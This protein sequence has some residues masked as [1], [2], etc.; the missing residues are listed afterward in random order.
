MRRRRRSAERVD[1]GPKM[2]VMNDDSAVAA[3]EAG[4]KGDL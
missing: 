2:A 4:P 1:F 3:V